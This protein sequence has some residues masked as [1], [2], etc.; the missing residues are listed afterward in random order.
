MRC[1]CRKSLL[2][3]PIR[4]GSQPS[5]AFANQRRSQFQPGQA[6]LRPVPWVLHAMSL[7]SWLF[8][9]F[10]TLLSSSKANYCP[11][12]CPLPNFLFCKTLSD[13]PLQT[14]PPRRLLLRNPM[15]SAMCSSY[16]SPD[17]AQNAHPVSFLLPAIKCA[18]AG[19]TFALSP[20]VAK[21][22]GT[23]SITSPHSRNTRFK[24]GHPIAKPFPQVPAEP[25]YP[26]EWRCRQGWRSAPPCSGRRSG[27]RPRHCRRAARRARHSRTPWWWGCWCYSWAGFHRR[28]SRWAGG[29]DPA[30]VDWS[31]RAGRTPLR[32]CLLGEQRHFLSERGPRNHGMNIRAFGLGEEGVLFLV[33]KVN[34][35]NLS[36]TYL[37]KPQSSDMAE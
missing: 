34:N 33:T 26:G 23:S 37:W 16:A 35:K 27:C 32:C 29:T 5:I 30:S 21:G 24:D 14:P 31:L 17:F 7:A 15:M 36:S 8:L 9:L 4:R 6:K 12:T 25:P 22:Y 10:L 19:P 11:Y 13:V 18:R 3:V 28:W 1:K 2:G 20:A